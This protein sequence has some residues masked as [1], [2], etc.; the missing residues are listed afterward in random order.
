MNEQEKQVQDRLSWNNEI[1]ESQISVSVINGN[2]TL[3]GCVTTYPEKVLAEIEASMVVGIKSINNEIEVKFSE[4]LES[5]SDKDVEEAMY[6]LLD[7]NS[8]INT[9]DVKVTV[10]EGI[11]SLEG[12][13]NSLWKREKI[14]KMAS[15][16][17]GVN[18]IKNNILIKPSKKISDEKI[19]DLIG[20]SLKNSVRI[21][22]E[23]VKINVE[24]GVVIVSGVVS[25]FV[26]YEAI[27]EIITST[28]GVL[29]S[30]NQLKW[31]HQ[32]DTT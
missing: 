7:A 12:K 14:Q 13:V 15:Q 28:N 17:K 20:K 29:D 19:K 24:D 22:S 3:K 4:K 30:K 8:E 10:K 1:D 31:I 23:N 16:I 5:R 18:S 27:I 26:E 25:S 2:A 32:Y 21:D 6:C 11:I 9:N